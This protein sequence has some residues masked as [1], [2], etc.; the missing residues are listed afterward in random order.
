MSFSNRVKKSAP[1]KAAVVLNFGAGPRAPLFEALRFPHLKFLTQAD[2]SD[3]G[4][5]SGVR[6]KRFRKDDASVAIEAEDVDVAVERDRQL[7]PLVR[8]IWQASEKPIDLLCKALA[9]CIERWSIKRRVAVDPAGIAIAFEDGPEG[10]RDRH[11]RLGIDLVGEG[12]DK[13]IHPLRSS[14][15]ATLRHR[16]DPIIRRAVLGLHGI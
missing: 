15:A 6:A 1:S 5:K 2:K 14:L 7:V 9:A 10:G 11:A 16:Q 12:G 3:M 8:I 13:A 4:R